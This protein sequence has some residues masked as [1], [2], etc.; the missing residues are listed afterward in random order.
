[1]TANLM[2]LCFK[3]DCFCTKGEAYVT[4]EWLT[5]FVCI[6]ARYLSSLDADCQPLV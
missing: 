1:M 2:L 4:C 6:P 5:Q 3:L